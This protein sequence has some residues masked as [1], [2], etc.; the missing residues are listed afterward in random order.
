MSDSPQDERIQG[1]GCAVVI[2]WFVGSMT[3]LIYFSWIGITG[4]PA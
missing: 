2:G 3:V 4:C 1:I